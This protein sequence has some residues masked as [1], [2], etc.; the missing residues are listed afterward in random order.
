MRTFATIVLCAIQ[1][2]VYGAIPAGLSHVADTTPTFGAALDVFGGKAYLS[3]RAGLIVFDGSSPAAPTVPSNDSFGDFKY[4]TRAIESPDGTIYFGASFDI[5][6]SPFKSRGAAVYQLEAPDSAVIEWE[7]L[8]A[9]GFDRSLNGFGYFEAWGNGARLSA[10]GDVTHV[11][12]LWLGGAEVTPNG[13]IAGQASPPGS[14]GVAAAMLLNDD[15]VHFLNSQGLL[16]SARDRNDGAGANFGYWGSGAYTVQYGDTTQFSVD[17]PLGYEEDGAQILVSQSDFVVFRRTGAPEY[18]AFFPGVNPIADNLSVPLIEVFPELSSV[19]INRVHDIASVDG[20]L[21]MLF[22]GDDGLWLYTAQDP[23]V[24]PEPSSL[25]VL[26]ALVCL[27]KTRRC[28]AGLHTAR[29]T[30]AL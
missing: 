21:Y 30:E 25:A 20:N 2:T 19:N 6:R 13:V 15:S 24:V 29:H 5:D 1:S 11:S 22:S 4:T 7:G 9:A 8:N 26:V 18:R 10:N 28:G 16:T 17:S 12:P 3:G 14:L 27:L 23:S